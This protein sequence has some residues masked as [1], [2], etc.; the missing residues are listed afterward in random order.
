LCVDARNRIWAEGRERGHAFSKTVAVH[1]TAWNA[2]REAVE[3]VSTGTADPPTEALVRAGKETEETVRTIQTGL[4][5]S[6]AIDT[7]RI[8]ASEAR[9]TVVGVRATRVDPQTAAD[10]LVAEVRGI[11]AVVILLASAAAG[12]E[13]TRE[14]SATGGK[15]GLAD[16]TGGVRIAQQ[17]SLRTCRAERAGLAPRRATIGVPVSSTVGRHARIDGGVGLGA[18]VRID[19][20]VA[21]EI[22]RRRRGSGFATAGY[23]CNG[24]QYTSEELH[25]WQPVD[26]A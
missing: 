5:G 3:V 16:G 11:V 17:V 9:N 15:T 21:S 26:R 25:D 7:A 13:T 14:V 1:I 22:D 2:D 6:S 18:A 4:A 20:G 24:Q 8:F 23:R 19:G 10:G 12:H